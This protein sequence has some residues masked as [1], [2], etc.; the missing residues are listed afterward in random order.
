MICFGKSSSAILLREKLRVNKILLNHYR[1]VASLKIG[2]AEYKPKG[3]YHK[4]CEQKFWELISGDS[5]LYLKI[6]EPLGAKAKEKMKN[7]K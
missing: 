5:S 4:I 6:V 2:T 7:L 1:K 3:D